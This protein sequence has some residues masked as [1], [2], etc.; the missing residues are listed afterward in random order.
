VSDLY[1]EKPIRINTMKYTGT[2]NAAIIAWADA[3][4]DGD[5]IAIFAEGPE[6]AVPIY[7]DIATLLLNINVGD[8]VIRSA[9]A[10]YYPMEP[11]KFDKVYGFV[12]EAP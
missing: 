9:R 2:N 12:D 8:W 7:K 5:N 11:A 6:F 1:A 3:F 4:N 10:E